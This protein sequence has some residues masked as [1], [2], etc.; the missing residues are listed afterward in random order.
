MDGKNLFK[1]TKKLKKRKSQFFNKSAL[2]KK[3]SSTKSKKSEK[4]THF[5]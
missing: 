4:F 5:K 1:F 2:E 3:L